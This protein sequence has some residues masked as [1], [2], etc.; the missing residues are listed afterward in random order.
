MKICSFFGH[1]DAP[2]SIEGALCKVLI[3]LIENHSV[4]KFYVGN[5][6]NFDAVVKRSLKKLKKSYPHISCMVVLAYLPSKKG[7]TERN[8]IETIFP[9]G[10]EKCPPKFA[11]SRRNRWMVD[12]S[13]YIVTYVNRTFGGAAQFKELAERKGK[14]VINLTERYMP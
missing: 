4:A 2:Q 7:N 1:S 12:N 8:E 10:L 6:G 11:I 9:E 3:D 5:N 13:D 14:T